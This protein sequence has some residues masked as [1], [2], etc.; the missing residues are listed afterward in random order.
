MSTD[1][2]I[3]ENDLQVLAPRMEMVLPANLPVGRLHQTVMVSL[4][5]TPALLECS[6][7]SIMQAAMTF[8]ILGLEVDGVTGQGYMIPFKKKAT[9]VIGYRGFNTL[10]A[11][12]NYT[13]T[14]DVIREGDRFEYQKGSSPYLNH[15]AD[16]EQKGKIQGAWALGAT[17]G[18]PPIIEVLPIVELMLVKERSPG[19]GR[20]DSPWNDPAIGFPAMCQKTAK[21]RLARSMPL[22]VMQVGA[23]IDG[24]Y[25]ELGRRG[26]I[27]PDTMLPV[28]EDEAEPAGVI[29]V[30]ADEPPEEPFTVHLKESLEPETYATAAEFDRRLTEALTMIEANSDINAERLARFW[31]RNE[32]QLAR[33]PDVAQARLQAEFTRIHTEK[34][35][36]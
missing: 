36:D 10:G 27:D 12:S 19:A 21:R 17:A 6:I 1:I 28:I 8:A 34:S 26:Y 2:A 33:L 30:N 25:E 22:N 13:I 7:P 18:R 3:I 35:D 32:M 20:S 9:P 24:A 16:P 4:E 29:D 23:A 31:K 15:I 11:R 5:R 14:G